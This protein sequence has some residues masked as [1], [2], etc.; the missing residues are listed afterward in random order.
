MRRKC[1]LSPDYA[2]MGNTMSS[3]M[4]GARFAEERKRVGFSSGLAFA[5]AAGVAQSS[6]N[7]LENGT[8]PPSA[9]ALK[10]LAA[11][12]GDVHYVLTGQRRLLSPGLLDR[13]EEE[14]REAMR[15]VGVAVPV[16]QPLRARAVARTLQ[17]M[18][19]LPSH[20]GDEQFEGVAQAAKS[21]CEEAASVVGV[22]GLADSWLRHCSAWPPDSARATTIQATGAHHRIAGRDI[23]ESREAPKKGS[24]R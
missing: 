10:K 22:E 11:R 1:A 7:R 18:S 17:I 6:I 20:V 12:G 16:G 21:A 15:A 14:L 9:E 2:E 19:F 3:D 24:K 13:V 23:N 8:V 4:T 5:Q